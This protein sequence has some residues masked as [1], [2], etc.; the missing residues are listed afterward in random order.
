M[1]SNLNY[2]LELERAVELIKNNNA[3]LV[4]VQLPDGFKQYAGEIQLDLESKTDAKI[5]IW[6]GSCFGAC[7]IPVHIETLGV[8]L[9][10][11]WGHSEY[12][13]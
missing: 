8:D 5:V 2:D 13:M 11:Q 1:D 3:K 7:D 12:I 4:C 10:L 6:L 9:L